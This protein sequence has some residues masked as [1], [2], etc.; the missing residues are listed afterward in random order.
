MSA[1]S[2]AAASSPAAAPAGKPQRLLSLDAFRGITILGMIL[3]NNPGSW[4]PGYRYAPLDHAAW[5]GW[6]PTDFV[7]PFFLFIVG[8]SLSYSLRKYRDGDQVAPAVYVRIV[9]RAVVLFLLGVGLAL[10][11]NAWD[12]ASGAK[13][14]MGLDTLRILGVLQRIALV[15]LVASLIVLHMRLRGQLALAAAILLGYWACLAWLPDRGDH[16]SNLSPQGNFVRVVDLAVLGANHMYTQAAEEQTEPEGLLSTLPAIVTAL[17]GYWSG[18]VI[19]QQGAAWRTVTTLAAGGLLAAAVGLA[20]DQ[21]FPINKKLWTS[22]FVL[23]TGG[24]GMI[25]L[26]LCLGLF[27]VA[28][29]RRLAHALAVVGV[30]AI[31]V[32]VGAGLLGRVLES[33]KVGALTTQDWLFARGFTD[34]IQDPKLASLGFALCCVA[35]WWLVAWLMSLRGWAIRV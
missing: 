13:P 7:F 12:Y 28:R 1:G 16:A 14:T 34:H 19:Q 25:G 6:T 2:T 9:R 15:Y 23:F 4:A 3:V 18:L 21:A 35:F 10:F 20:W 27:D 11:G 17:M 22:S 5:H 8:A 31:T 24:L 33:T 29:W 26:G 32:F 30:N